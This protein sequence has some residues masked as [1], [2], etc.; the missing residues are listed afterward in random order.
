MIFYWIFFQIHFFNCAFQ[1]E[2]P[3]KFYKI[4]QCNFCSILQI[5]VGLQWIQSHFYRYRTLEYGFC[6]NY[7]VL[8]YQNLLAIVDSKGK[9]VFQSDNIGALSLIKEF[10]SSE[11]TVKNIQ[12]NIATNI[13]NEASL[14]VV[15]RVHPQLL[16]LIRQF[17]NMK[18]SQVFFFSHLPFSQTIL[19]AWI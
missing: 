11:A 4:V 9:A 14:A 8:I 1:K 18:F 15:R 13:C 17:N 5:P 16:D 2:N 10:I 3:R 7:L 19:K 12:L 6:I